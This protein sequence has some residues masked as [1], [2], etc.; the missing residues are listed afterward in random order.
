MSH[1]FGGHLPDP[2]DDKYWS[3]GAQLRPHLA[4]SPGDADLRPY[5]SPRQDQ[6]DTNTCVAQ[7]TV[8]ALENL[9]RQ[10]LCQQRGISPDRL[11][12]DDHHNLS[13]LALYYLCRERMNPPTVHEDSGTYPALACECLRAFGVCTEAAWP[14]DPAKLLR[15]PSVMALRD[16]YVHKV[17]AYYRIT[18]TGAARVQSVLDALR[19]NYPVVYGTNIGNNWRNYKAGQVLQLPAASLGGHATHLVG[20]DNRAGA[21]IGENSWGA[22]W[23]DDGFYWLAP[24]V[25]ADAS[26]RDFWVITGTWEDVHQ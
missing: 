26:S 14:Y 20:W 15:A 21:F 5:S 7:A 23:G 19:S 2:D 22:D 8:K 12:P 13:V 17:S 24:E 18:E 4:P 6:G 10:H 3:F 25:I 1:T 11:G 16:A 9:E